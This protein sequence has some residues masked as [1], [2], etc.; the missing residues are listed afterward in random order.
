M[1]KFKTLS[2]PIAWLIGIIAA[3]A[4]GFEAD[5]YLEHV[6]NIP[7]PHPYPIDTVLWVVGL[8]TVQVALLFAILRPSSFKNSWGRALLA[9]ISSLGFLTLGVMGVMHAPPPWGR[10]VFWLLAMAL[11]ML[12]ITLQ[13]AIGAI[14]AKEEA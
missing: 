13:S 5:P 4:A 14:T 1:Q 8:M 9:F 10:Y 7:L 11:A 3:V 2:L 12:S 6:R